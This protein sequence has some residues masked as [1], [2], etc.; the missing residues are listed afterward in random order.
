MRLLLKRPGNDDAGFRQLLDKLF[1]S[2]ATPSPRSHQPRYVLIP[3]VGRQ[4]RQQQGTRHITLAGRDAAAA[5]EPAGAH[6]FIKHAPR[7]I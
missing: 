7:S 5:F 3:P 1:G 4:N 2:A 6:P